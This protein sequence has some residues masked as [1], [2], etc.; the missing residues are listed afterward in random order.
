M[1]CSS[2][3]GLTTLQTNMDCFEVCNSTVTHVDSAMLNLMPA[4]PL[5]TRQLTG[6]YSL[7]SSSKAC[8]R[9]LKL[10]QGKNSLPGLVLMHAA[11]QIIEEGMV[12]CQQWFVA[13]AEVYK[14]TGY[15]L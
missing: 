11:D 5:S 10:R 9:L 13:P 6:Q 3:C 4:M 7:L 12:C 14:Q 15:P 1:A 2:A 8:V